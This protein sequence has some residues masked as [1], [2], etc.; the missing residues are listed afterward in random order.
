VAVVLPNGPELAATFLAVS[1]TA[2]CAPLNPGYRAS[3][4]EFYLYALAPK[5]LIVEDE[6]DSPALG[7]AEARGTRVIRMRR[8]AESPSGVF[9]LDL[10]FAPDPGEVEPSAAPVPAESDD[11]ALVLFSVSTRND[12]G[13]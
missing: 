11:E 2:A 9:S 13:V 1:M 5:A 7:V 6:T 12:S 4:Y 3:E 8:D 10:T